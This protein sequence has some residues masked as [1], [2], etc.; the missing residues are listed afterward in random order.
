MKAA[1]HSCP[2]E[3]LLIWQGEDMAQLVQTPC[4]SGSPAARYFLIRAIR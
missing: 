1:I 2:L 3:H 4:P